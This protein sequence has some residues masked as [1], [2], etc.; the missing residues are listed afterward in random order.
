MRPLSW[1][2]LIGTL[3]ESS[4]DTDNPGSSGDSVTGSEGPATDELA[5]LSLSA[6]AAI[7]KFLPPAIAAFWPPA[8]SYETT[9]SCSIPPWRIPGKYSL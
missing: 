8:F 5:S 1:A 6:T 3:S 9:D 7:Y 2:A 4:N